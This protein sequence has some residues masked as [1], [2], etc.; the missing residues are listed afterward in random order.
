MLSKFRKREKDRPKGLISNLTQDPEAIQ[1]IERPAVETTH[2]YEAA[3]DPCVL[4]LVLYLL[5]HTTRSHVHN[6]HKE[7]DYN[8]QYSHEGYEDH[9]TPMNVAKPFAKKWF[10]RKGKG[11]STGTTNVYDT[12]QEHERPHA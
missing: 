7:Y 4:Y 8:E 12:V 6:H 10:F 5:T 3:T 11:K 2:V 1:E 9:E